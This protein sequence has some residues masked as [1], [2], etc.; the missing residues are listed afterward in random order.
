[1]TAATVSHHLSTLKEAG[2]VSAE[3]QGRTIVYSLNATVV[4]ELVGDLLRNLGVGK[5]S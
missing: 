4:Q 2:L 5:P 3:R 1:M